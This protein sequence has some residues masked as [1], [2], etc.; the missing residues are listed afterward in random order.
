MKQQLNTNKTYPKK[1]L[2]QNFIHD[3]NFILKL[4]D[5]ILCDESTNIFEIGPGLG[6][7]TE[8]LTK[9][10]FNKLILIEK[11]TILFEKLRN[12]FEEKNKIYTVNSDALKYNY[13]DFSQN[14]SLIIGNLPFNIS[15]QLLIHWI[16]DYNWPPFYR[17]MVLMFQKE[18]AERII[19]KHNQK[20]YGRISV[21]TQARCNVKKLL[22]APSSI[23]FPRP[24]VDGVVLEFTP[25]DKNINL[26]ILNLQKLLRKSFEHRRKKIKTSLKDYMNILSELNIDS[27]LRAENLSVDD[28]CKIASAI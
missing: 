27:N 16:V 17:K 22:N 24:K 2:G 25:I 21:I 3:K 12:K 11:D 28:Y 5:L 18:V 10:Q 23:F 8:L 7:L 13:L 6:A 9:K 4:S 19:A 26:N 15:T 20:D 1:S 14:D